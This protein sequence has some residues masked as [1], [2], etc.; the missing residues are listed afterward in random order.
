MTCLGQSGPTPV[1]CS[2]KG[3]MEQDEW[4]SGLSPVLCLV[5]QTVMSVL[6]Q[7]FSHQTAS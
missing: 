7:Q 4:T 2:V 6:L 1:P 3:G 5:P